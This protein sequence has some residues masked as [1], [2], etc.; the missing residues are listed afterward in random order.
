MFKKILSLM[1]VLVLSATA[2]TVTFADSSGLQLSGGTSIILKNASGQRYGSESGVYLSSMDI[3]S[4][5]GNMYVYVATEGKSL[6]VFKINSDDTCELVQTV[7][8]VAGETI[9]TSKSDENIKVTQVDG[10]KYLIFQS[11]FKLYACK[12][13]PVN[14]TIDTTEA[15]TISVNASS[16][17]V[18]I[19]LV[20]DYIFVY[21]SCKS[22]NSIV[23]V[24]T[25]ENDSFVNRGSIATTLNTFTDIE[26]IAFGADFK[27]VYENHTLTG[28]NMYLTTKRTIDGTSGY[29]FEIHKGTVNNDKSISFEMLS[30][31]NADYQTAANIWYN[32][33]AII[34]DT[35]AVIS[36]RTGKGMIFDIS[37]TSAPAFISNV[38]KCGNYTT[39]VGNGCY[40]STSVGYKNGVGLLLWDSTHTMTGEYIYSTN[41]FST[42]EIKIYNG[43]AYSITPD[44]IFSYVKY[45]NDVLIENS[46]TL[47][48]YPVLQGTVNGYNGEAVEI[49]VNNGAY[50]EMLVDCFGSFSYAIEE[51]GLNDAE[52]SIRYAGNEVISENVSFTNPYT[53]LPSVNG[54]VSLEIGNVDFIGGVNCSVSGTTAGASEGD[55]VIVTAGNSVAV[56]TVG[57]DGTFSTEGFDFKDYSGFIRVRATLYSGYIQIAADN[58]VLEYSGKNEFYIRL[59]NNKIGIETGINTVTAQIINQQSVPHENVSLMLVLY[60]DNSQKADIRHF[61]AIPTAGQIGI[62]SAD[63]NIAE[64]DDSHIKAFIFEKPQAPVLLSNVPVISDGADNMSASDYTGNND[65]NLNPITDYNLKQVDTNIYAPTHSGETFGLLVF[66]PG[67]T[68]F[69]GLEYINTYLIGDNAVNVSFDVLSDCEQDLPFNVFVTFGE[70]AFVSK[71]FRYYGESAMLSL[72]NRINNA[73]SD[74]I[75]RIINNENDIVGIDISPGSAY[76]GMK[77]TEYLNVI[78]AK[79][80]D[81]E[82]ASVGEFTD[83]V[84]NELKKQLL[85]IE[86]NSFTEDQMLEFISDESKL[87]S[88]SIDKKHYVG[89]LDEKLKKELCGVIIQK[90]SNQVFYDTDVLDG[91]VT[92]NIIIIAAN[93][94]GY[95]TM[96]T[97]LRNLNE[98]LGISFTAYDNLTAENKLY[99][100]KQLARTDFTVSAK[101]KSVFD[102]AVSQFTGVSSNPG[103][104]AG[105]GGESFTVKPSATVNTD[106]L[107]K[108]VEQ[109]DVFND[110]Q[111]VPW[112]KESIRMLYSKGVLNGY[113]DGSF[114]PDLS[115][116]REEYVKMIVCAFSLLDST[117]E[118]DFDDVG[119]D[120][121]YYSYVS[122]A[123]S[124]GLI[125]GLEEQVFGAG[126]YLSRQDLAVMLYRIAQYKNIKISNSGE[127]NVN[128]MATVSD[129]AVDAVETMIRGGVMTG[130]G[131]NFDPHGNVTRAMAAKVIFELMKYEGGV[132]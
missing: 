6:L 56:A 80:V 44:G 116:T 65:I 20:D 70:N 90:I 68:G 32:S 123:H 130:D 48:G 110:L 3:T 15:F 47:D 31:L 12:I 50:K 38:E 122:S 100:L 10:I 33:V 14:G 126:R 13:N 1:L 21:Q 39:A 121:W 19:K 120:A 77:N 118:C 82:F 132:Q 40:I 117:A 37:D 115:V 108:P 73:D 104:Y 91:F 124:A 101:I 99:V 35:S 85:L 25:I 51:T 24:Y 54:T 125:N 84:N 78:I 83:F 2:V 131:T 75:I 119:K 97:L 49:S 29:Y 81:T 41:G 60:T 109:S 45:S 58:A 128:D 72:R 17:Y 102:S 67:M 8:S 57:S 34:D 61:E 59:T 30:R 96:E 71:G 11:G 69:D 106:G 7:T 127:S 87:D 16:T 98:S 9:N 86:F 92:E 79:A 129:Y 74:G 103:G 55:I 28:F 88:L 63:F 64:A 46:Y 53:D 76:D 114:K 107:V 89:I 18:G 93:N 105:G 22:T 66:K 26:E 111:A 94:A 113:I 27:P 5:N 62:C 43:Y 4:V 112:A 36:T 23:N 52:I 42:R 95:D